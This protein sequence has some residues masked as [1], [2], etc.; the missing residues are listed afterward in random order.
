MLRIVA[1]DK[2][3]FLKG[4]LEPHAEIKYL[5]G[6]RI[7]PETIRDAD[8]MLIRTRTKCTHALLHRSA[9]KFIATATIGFDHIDTAFCKSE[10]IIWH[11]AP[12]CNSASVQQYVASALPVL[13]KYLSTELRGKVIGIVGVGNVGTK[14]AKIAAAFGMKVLLNDPPRARKEGS[15]NFVSL[16][17]IVETADIITLHVPLLVSGDDRTFHLFDKILLGKMK[18]G[19]SLI[20]T[21]RGEVIETKAL[22]KA[23]SEKKIASAVID[24][25]ENE[26]FINQQL[27]EKVLIATPHI[28]GYSADGKANGTAMVVQALSKHF[29]LPLTG[30][31]P[32]A[33]PGPEKPGIFIDCDK[34]NTE[35]ILSEAFLHTYDIW[36]DDQ[37]L[38]YSPATFEQQRGNYPV[39]REFQA[40]TVH[41]NTTDLN[42]IQ[43]LNDLGFKVIQTRK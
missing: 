11:N 5:P 25:W 10:N 17:E 43:T 13:G 40:F 37:T 31:F 27:M 36:T 30:W 35:E 12:G 28:A 2:I 19:A 7:T 39:R 6:N 26:P 9:V 8:A 3:P 20:N 16:D 4:V 14:V 21:A 24:V 1:D 15:G 41:I 23:L 33:I 42:T 38:R 18:P 34:K 22:I 29:G 32:D